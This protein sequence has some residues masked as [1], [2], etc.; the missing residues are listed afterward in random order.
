MRTR[1]LAVA[2]ALLSVPHLAVAQHGG[3]SAPDTRAPREASQFNFLIGQWELSVKPK[4]TSLAARIHGVP[5]LQGTWKAWRAL[6][7][8]GIE[9]EMRIVDASGNP[10]SLLHSVRIFDPAARHWRVSALDVYRTSSTTTST[11]WQGTEM[12]SLPQESLADGKPARSRTRITHITANSFR[13]HQDHSTD[14]GR[15]WIEDML[16]IDAKRV[17][18]TAAR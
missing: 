13:Y 18:A 1:S 3:E 15:T 17:A 8:W 7:G 9:D 12:R 4:A 16:V 10:R 2:L 6:E 11:Q 5:K 14:G